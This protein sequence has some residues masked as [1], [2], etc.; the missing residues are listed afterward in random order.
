MVSIEEILLKMRESRGSDEKKCKFCSTSGAEGDDA[1]RSEYYRRVIERYAKVVS[2][3]EEK[4]I[5]ELKRLVAPDD[6]V[7]LKAEELKEERETLEFVKKLPLLHAGLSVSFWLSPGESLELG[8]GDV[9]DKAVL[10][11]SLL[12]AQGANAFLRVVELEGGAKHPVVVVKGERESRVLDA[13]SGGVFMGSNAEA[14]LVRSSFEGK[15]YSCSLYE[16]NAEDYEAF[17]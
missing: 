2:F 11:C 17:Q 8:A 7:K 12:L 14:A 5:P 1:L 10:L 13:V 9:M 4:S 15:A 16:F 6:C 3:G